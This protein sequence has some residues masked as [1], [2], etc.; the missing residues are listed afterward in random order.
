MA[1]VA[2]TASV[3]LAGMAV[4]T[5]AQAASGVT[6]GHIGCFN[7]S[8][9]DGISTTTVYFHN[10]CKH[11]ATINIWWKDGRIDYMRAATVKAN[12][13]GHLKHTGSIKSIYG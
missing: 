8:Y 6:R 3:L 4:A 7:Y 11:T 2:V 1:K 5:P 9:G 13:K 10:I 12:G